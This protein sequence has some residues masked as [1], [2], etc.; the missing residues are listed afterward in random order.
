MAKRRI[1]VF[2]A[3]CQVCQPT[4]DLVKKTACQNCEVVVYDL[5][6]G[7]E[8]NECR[9]KAHQYNITRIPAVV[10]DGKLLDCCKDLAITEKSLRDAGVGQ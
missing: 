1:E 8:T 3:G 4:V 2:T 9:D 5:N 10:V 6:T 7:C